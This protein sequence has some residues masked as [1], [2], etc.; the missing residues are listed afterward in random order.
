MDSSAEAAVI[1]NN[2]K[3]NTEEFHGSGAVSQKHSSSWEHLRDV[4]EAWEL[5]V[6]FKNKE[7]T[8]GKEGFCSKGL[9]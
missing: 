1:G 4:P 9:S 8:Q 2:S 7:T 5:E 6:I 3:G